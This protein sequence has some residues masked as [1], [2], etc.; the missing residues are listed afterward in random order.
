MLTPVNNDFGAIQVQALQLYRSGAVIA[1]TPPGAATSQ[2]IDL[3]MLAF[4]CDGI[5]HSKQNPNNCGVLVCAIAEHVLH[6]IPMNFSQ[7]DIPRMRNYIAN[8]L[9]K[10]GQLGNPKQPQAKLKD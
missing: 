5:H 4:L 8:T 6:G 9:I 10:E 2:S 1:G 7:E 3:A